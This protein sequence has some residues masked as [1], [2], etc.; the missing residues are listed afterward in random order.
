MQLTAATLS[1]LVQSLRSQTGEGEKRQQP[2]VGLR[3][4][5]QLVVNDKTIAVWVRDISSGGINLSCPKDIPL[6]TRVEIVLSD[7]DQIGCIVCHCHKNGPHL[8]HR[9]EIHQRR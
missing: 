9:G 6:E 3:A 8:C 1:E 2:R 4:K 7:A 5:A